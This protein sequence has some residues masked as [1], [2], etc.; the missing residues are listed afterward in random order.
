MGWIESKWRHSEALAD[1]LQKEEIFKINEILERN[2]AEFKAVINK[3][4][5]I[6]PKVEVDMPYLSTETKYTNYA[7]DTYR[8]AKTKKVT[9]R[10]YKLVTLSPEFVSK[11]KLEI[12]SDTI[13]KFLDKIS[14]ES[15]ISHIKKLDYY[16]IV[17]YQL[18]QFPYSYIDRISITM[19]DEKKK[20]I[21]MSNDEPLEDKHF[22][23]HVVGKYDNK[24]IREVYFLLPEKLK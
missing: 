21:H 19:K 10:I 17:K 23:F 16:R 6:T 22:N 14:L 8:L 7:T 4:S 9:G 24:E 12:Y 18:Y 5:V 15:N 13:I 11:Y 1:E 2:G 3:S 20:L